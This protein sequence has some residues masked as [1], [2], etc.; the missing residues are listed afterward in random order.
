MGDDEKIATQ[1][2]AAALPMLGLLFLSRLPDYAR[3][4]CLKCRAKLLGPTALDAHDCDNP[5]PTLLQ[6]LR[7]GPP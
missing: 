1:A 3:V 7:E 2:A 6:M 5:E 4:D